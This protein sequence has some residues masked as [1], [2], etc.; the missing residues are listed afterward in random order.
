MWE[1]ME[2]SF[3]KGRKFAEYRRFKRWLEG[4]KG[5]YICSS[6]TQ[7]Q[8]IKDWGFYQSQVRDSQ[9]KFSKGV[10]NAGKKAGEIYHQW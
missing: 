1:S 10:E 2:V 4:D 6:S 9:G 8:C 5:P 7:Q 3:W